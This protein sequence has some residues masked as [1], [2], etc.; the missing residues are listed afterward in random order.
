MPICKKCNQSFPNT[1]KLEGITRFLHKRNF[2]LSC[3]PFGTHNTKSDLS[4]QQCG[5]CDVLLT[6]DNA[7]K[8]SNRSTF[9][10][11]C[12]KCHGELHRDRLREFKCECVEYKG[13][14]CEI[15]GY[16]RCI[17]ALEFH[18]LDPSVKEFSISRAAT[19]K[20]SDRIKLELDKC[21]LL[22][23]RCHREKHAEYEETSPLDDQRSWS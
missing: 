18:H 9:H 6:A 12:K 4:Q 14:K 19:T 16:N 1:I 15:C 7:F 8:R 11:Y 23:C 5:S 17:S 3:S 10:H 20:L 13:G 22:C 21:Q 2:C